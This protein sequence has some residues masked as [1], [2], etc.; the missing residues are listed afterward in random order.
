MLLSLRAIFFVGNLNLLK[1]L[2]ERLST[3]VIHMK[4]ALVYGGKFDWRYYFNC[5]E[6]VFLVSWGGG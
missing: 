5:C 6:V 2:M 3:Q 1:I 4:A